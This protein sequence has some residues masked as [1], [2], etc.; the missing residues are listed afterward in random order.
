MDLEKLKEFITILKTKVNE[1]LDEL[2][3]ASPSSTTFNT[4]I[5][6]IISITALIAKLESEL[7]KPTGRGEA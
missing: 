1:G 7:Q 3:V 4:L 6:N 2:T 5:Q